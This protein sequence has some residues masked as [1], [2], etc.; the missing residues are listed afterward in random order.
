MSGGARAEVKVL[1]FASHR[2]LVGASETT[3]VVPKGTTMEGILMSLRG[4]GEPWSRLPETSA[5]ALNRK[6]VS[7]SVVARDGDE[8]ALIPPVAGG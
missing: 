5:M 3:V 7:A 1:F 8:V 4:R 2:D 6:Y